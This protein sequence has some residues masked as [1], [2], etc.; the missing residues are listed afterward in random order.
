MS[1][2]A[3]SAAACLTA[4]RLASGWR[5]RSRLYCTAVRRA[6]GPVGLRSEGPDATARHVRTG[7]L[8][9]GHDMHRPR[10]DPRFID[11]IT[12]SPDL[13]TSFVMMES[14]G[15]SLSLKKR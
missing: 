3:R 4:R 9:L 10:P 7:G 14:Y 12:Q 11:A 5:P 15:F 2:A 8:I 13:D 1:P 6:R